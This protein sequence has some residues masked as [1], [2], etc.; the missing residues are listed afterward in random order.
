MAK[1]L[2]QTSIGINNPTPDSTAVFDIA[3]TS[4]GM[5]LPRMTTAQR[6]AIGGPASGLLVYD[7]NKAKF[8]F[9]NGSSWVAM[10]TSGALSVM[11]SL[12]VEDTASNKKIVLNPV[13]GA[14]RMYANDTLWYE[15][16]VNSV[17]EERLILDND[18]TYTR[19]GTTEAIEDAFNMEVTRRQMSH[20]YMSSE[21]LNAQYN[22]VCVAQTDTGGCRIK[23]VTAD[24][25]DSTEHDLHATGMS[26][27]GPGW[28]N[29]SSC[30]GFY[31]LT[32]SPVVRS[33][34][35]RVDTVDGKVKI[36]AEN[37]IQGITTTIEFKVDTPGV[38]TSITGDF[39][40]GGTLSKSAG[41]FKIDHPLDPYN[42]YLYHSFV[43]S[44]DMMNIYNGNISTDAKGEA[45]VV[46]PDYFEALNMDFRYQ[47][48]VI[49]SF[50]QAIVWK[51]IEN[52]QFLIR[53]SDPNVKVSWMVTGVRQ[54]PYANDNRI[55]VEAVKEKS[56][57]G[58]LLYDH[59]RAS[60]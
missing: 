14:I 41:T 12:V 47:L 11:D 6:T 27:S 23:V 24:G 25:T 8:F 13:D 35:S 21:Y 4:K 48:T 46:L 3:S 7:T 32:T 55:K 19:R 26:S 31:H 60:R 42:K 44:P 5:L 38:G 39:T 30:G 29:S 37:P 15:S 53:T 33:L 36:T 2:A 20:G 17:E 56:E 40:I 1:I 18:E 51:E 45:T 34:W 10:P 49:G 43:E 28:I 59:H 57:R 22:K 54:D 58:K 16:M 9:Y 50:S 52:N